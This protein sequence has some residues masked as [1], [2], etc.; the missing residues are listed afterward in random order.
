MTAAAAP[1]IIAVRLELDALATENRWRQAGE[2]RDDLLVR[3]EA[4]EDAA[5]RLGHP[6][7]LGASLLRRGEI[8]LSAERFPQAIE[9]LDKGLVALG[10]LRQHD[11][12]VRALAMLA[13]ANAALG[14]WP[15][16]DRV[17][18]KGID[19]AESFRYK[20]TAPYLQ[21]AYLGPRIDLYTIGV[22][23]ALRL[24]DMEKML[25]RAELSKSRSVLSY[26]GA[27]PEEAANRDLETEFRRICEQVDSAQGRGKVPD[28]LLQKRRAVWDLLFIQRFKGRQQAGSF[29]IEAVRN[30]LAKD[31]AAID[32]YWLDRR[33]LLIVTIDHRAVVPEVREV[34][35]ED[36]SRL[37]RFASFVL[38]FSQI[39]PPGYLDAVEEFS[40]I[41]LPSAEEAGAALQGKARLVLSP[42]RL[43]HAIPFHALRWKK[44]YL[45]ER[46]AISYVPNL[47]T[48]TLRFTP[49][50]E[51]RV[52]AVGVRDYEVP[53]LPLPPLPEAEEEVEDLSRLY[54]EQGVGV[55][56]LVGPDGRERQLQ[57]L[58]EDGTLE[59]CT[60]L[61]FAT[62]GFNVSGDTP[63]ESHLFLRDSLL[64]GLEI[65]RWNLSA[66]LVVLS[67]CCSGQQAIAGRGMAELPGDELFGLQAAFFAAGARRVMGCLWP[68]DTFAAKEITKSFHRE[69]GSGK[70][71]EVALQA[72]TLEF[73]RRAGPLRRKVFY[74]APFFL[75]CLGRPSV[76][77]EGVGDGG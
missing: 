62:H 47:T 68:V 44:R 49:P 76:T 41:L 15:A 8:L 20:V 26:S 70:S 6:E 32:Y 55:V 51:H 29:S 4:L 66:E 54:L 61:H 77:P 34:T 35:E 18:Q 69:L 56:K 46:F 28:E 9:A 43:L 27:A 11:L 64:D 59:A 75:S 65:S 57:Q 3:A 33:T 16:A 1:D 67:A 42:H 12:G 25:E 30:A 23:A 13:Q 53:G 21:S 73:L 24:G 39:S 50:R 63:L 14:E 36:R 40:P 60:R 10:E 22:R 19:L 74:W 2:P 48:L 38:T 58:E 7:V 45:I 37:D 31:E 52:L 72:A 5:R 71:A 17:C